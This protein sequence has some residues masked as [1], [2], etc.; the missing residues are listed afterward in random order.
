[1]ARR[2]ANW[3]VYSYYTNYQICL[4]KNTW[5]LYRDDGLAVLRNT[6]G[7]EAD[8]MRKVVVQFF[9]K[10]AL[11]VTID[12][13]LTQTEFLHETFNLSTGKFWP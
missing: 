1:M 5:G 11:S 6:S 4:I 8:K 9:Q 2:Y 3:L 10:H 7:P 12:T 13:N